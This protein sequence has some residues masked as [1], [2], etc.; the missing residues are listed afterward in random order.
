LRRL[1]NLFFVFIFISNNKKLF[2][3]RSPE[4][5]RIKMALPKSYYFE[6]QERL[7]AKYGQAI[8][9]PARIR[10]LESL[11][12][13]GAQLFT[14]L[15]DVQPL[16]H[17]TVSNHLRLLERAGLIRYAEVYYGETGYAVVPTT[18]REACS[19]W[20]KMVELEARLADPGR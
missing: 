10:V 4:K 8:A 5:T 12:N 2:L 17:P 3:S 11:L 14:E 6:E 16:S 20:R 19:L 18:F 9:H 13:E 7:L 15:A 1:A